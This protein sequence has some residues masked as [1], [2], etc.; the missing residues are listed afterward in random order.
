MTMLRLS[1][2]EGKSHMIHEL[3]IQYEING[4]DAISIWPRFCIEALSRGFCHE[5]LC[6]S[7]AAPPRQY[8]VATDCLVGPEEPEQ[9]VRGQRMS[10]LGIHPDL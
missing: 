2:K 3:N 9:G 4:M 1:G 7:N 8:T 10:P 6:C 5:A